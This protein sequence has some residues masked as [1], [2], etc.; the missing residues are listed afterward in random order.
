MFIKICGITNLEDACTAAS[1]GADAVGLMMFEDSPR[2]ISLKEAVSISNAIPKEVTSVM[3]FVNPAKEYVQECIQAVPLATLQFHGSEDLSFC[4][5][6]NKSFIK[7]FQV[8]SDTNFKQISN[9]FSSAKMLLLDSKNKILKGGTGKTF[10]WDIISKDLRVP[11]ILAGGLNS[12]NVEAALT[13]VSCVGLDVSTGVESSPGKKDPEKIKE[14][15]T[16]VRNFN[17]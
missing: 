6:F 9:E 4:S 11:F 5:S 16:K 3:V 8:D 13:T 15:I 2:F 14:F 10:D 1:L 7:A 17:G 12:D